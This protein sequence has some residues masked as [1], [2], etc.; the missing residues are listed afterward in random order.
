MAESL[1]R[2]RGEAV[3]IAVGDADTI[4]QVDFSDF[5]ITWSPETPTIDI[6]TATASGETPLLI[7]AQ[8]GH[9]SKYLEIHHALLHVGSAAHV[10]A[11]GIALAQRAPQSLRLE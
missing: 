3:A 11:P 7:A 2:F 5:P 6:N 8:C 4:S 10:D 9:A 1:V